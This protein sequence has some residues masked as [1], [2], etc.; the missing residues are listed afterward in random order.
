QAKGR[1]QV[2]TDR[3]SQ[4]LP[5][6]VSKPRTKH[7]CIRVHLRESCN[8]CIFIWCV[9]IKPVE[10]CMYNLCLKSKFNKQ[11]SFGS[12]YEYVS[13]CANC[14]LEKSVFQ[15]CMKGGNVK[16]LLALK[17]LSSIEPKKTRI[18][19]PYLLVGGLLP[20][21]PAP[22]PPLPQTHVY[23]L[24]AKV[25][26]QDVSKDMAAWQR[27]GG[28]LV[29]ESAVNKDAEAE[30]IGWGGG[31]DFA[32][33]AAA[34]ASI[35]GWNWFKDPRLVSLG[36]RGI[37]PSDSLPPLVEA[38]KEVDEQYYL[39]WRLEEGVP[40]GSTEIPKGFNYFFLLYVYAYFYL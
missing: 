26:I 6:V 12:E 1:E 16:F 24:R 4:E 19:D 33:C 2:G 40:E 25:E 21:P 7:D 34:Q 36:F 37:F 22:L 3:V 32:G 9:S 30:G 5:E 28:V 17:D 10:L 14:G 27:F 18:G 31:S 39:L 13:V 35:Q 20:L 23:R 38:D 11:L 8:V 15:C 29:D